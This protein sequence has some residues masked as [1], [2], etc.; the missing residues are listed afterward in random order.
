MERELLDAADLRQKHLM[1]AIDTLRAAADR[2]ADTGEVIANRWAMFVSKP[3]Q[4]FRAA[5]AAYREL[6]K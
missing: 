4:D 1:E 5:M 2:M 6:G 3:W